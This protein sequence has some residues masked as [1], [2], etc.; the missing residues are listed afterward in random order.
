MTQPPVPLVPAPSAGRSPEA[1][2]T[3][4]I[5]VPDRPIRRTDLCRFPVGEPA[6]GQGTR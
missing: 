6:R 3:A 2:S 1:P 5:A 4:R